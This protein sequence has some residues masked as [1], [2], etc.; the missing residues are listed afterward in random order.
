MIEEASRSL[1]ALV[2]HPVTAVLFM[3]LVRA[4]MKTP[5]ASGRLLL[6]VV[7]LRYVMQA[8]HEW[9]Y[10]SVG[11]LS[12][13]A[14]ASLM[15]C[16][17]GGLLLVRR[18]PVLMRFPVIGT[19]VAVI[20]LSG[21]INGVASPTFETLLKWGYFAVILLAVVDCMERDG[22]HRILGLLLWAFAPPLVYQA[23]SI[24]LG[25]GKATE[26]DGS[27]SYIGG[28][29]HE[30][31]FSVI[32]VTCFAVASLAP[33][34][35]LFLRLCLLAACIAGLFAAN[36]RTSLIALAPLAAG[37]FVF[38][39]A[40]AVAPGRRVIVSLIGLLIMSG[41]ALIANAIVSDRMADLSALS[42]SQGL[43]RSPEEFSEADRKLLSGRLYIW[44]LYIDQYSAGRDPQLVFGYGADSWIDRFGVYA[45]NTFI[46]YLFEFGIAGAALIVMVLLGML[47][48][49]FTIRDWALRGQ[50][51]CTHLGF[52]CL[53]MATMPFW[54]IEG[55]ILYGLI[56]GYT[57]VLTTQRAAARQP[58]VRYQPASWARA[59][60]VVRPPP[61]AS[62]ARDLDLPGMKST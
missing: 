40:R 58:H 7:W 27:V 13:N 60:R 11:G 4:A 56:C 22:D 59:R 48:R 43:V 41:G 1:P 55:L 32:L 3:L 20:I 25:A 46:S 28:Y 44:N 36:Y 35:N 54:Q 38:G 18:L 52:V 45:H 26:S 37:Y 30:A 12:I 29:N 15:V 49:A 51:V 57:V 6:F 42:D 47:A 23:L 50:L 2:L 31:A 9:T 34:I 39:I 24:G 10:L 62:P 19:L 14:I 53:S 33:R 16:G 5:H 61:D 8:Y 21:L 17:V